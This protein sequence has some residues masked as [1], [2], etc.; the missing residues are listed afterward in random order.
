[1]TTP[2]RAAGSGPDPASARVIGM[3]LLGSAVVMVTVAALAYAGVLPV[4]ESVR[5]WLS[6]ALGVA[7][8]ADVLVAL[9]FLR[10]SSQP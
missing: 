1:M 7:A 4:A 10:A 2:P 5:G 3:S 9:Y 6:A 8:I